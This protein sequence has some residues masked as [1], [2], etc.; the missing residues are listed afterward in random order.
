MQGNLTFATFRIL[1]I[2]L[3]LGSFGQ[4]FLKKGLQGTVLVGS[5]LATT[6][7]NILHALLQPWVFLGLSLYVISTFFWVVV[8]SRVRLS[9]AYPM[10]SMS[11]FLVVLLS[12]LVLGEKVNWGLAVPGLL[13]ISGGVSFIG[14]GLGRAREAG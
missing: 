13:F 8:I 5:S 2:S 12:A 1:L 11:Y 7:V 6:L 3:A 4:V 10:I 9:V 14:L